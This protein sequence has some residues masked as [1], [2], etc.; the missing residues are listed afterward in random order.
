MPCS[1]ST[2]MLFPFCLWILLF[3][4]TSVA[5]QPLTDDFN[6]FVLQ[7]LDHWHV[8]GF[9]IAVVNGN[10]TFSKVPCLAPMTAR[11]TLC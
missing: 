1:L 3:S 10:E 4:S 5:D 8:P 7:T 6:A 9:S 11:P 2:V